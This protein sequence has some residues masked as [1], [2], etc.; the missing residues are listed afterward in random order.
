MFNRNENQS[1]DFSTFES[2]YK[3]L[4]NRNSVD[5]ASKISDQAEVIS[6]SL[7]EDIVF[8]SVATNVNRS[9][10]GK[11]FTI[12]NNILNIFFIFNF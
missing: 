7:V 6:F 1:I 9:Y 11:P 4:K 3:M 5:T 2:E 8:T 12:I 10:S